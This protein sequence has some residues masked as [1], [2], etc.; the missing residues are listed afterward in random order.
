MRSPRGSAFGSFNTLDAIG[1]MAEAAYLQH[2]SSTPQLVSGDLAASS[3]TCLQRPSIALR[4]SATPGTSPTARGFHTPKFVIIRA[5]KWLLQHPAHPVV[6][7]PPSAIPASSCTFHSLHLTACHFGPC[8]FL[9]HPTEAVFGSDF[10]RVLQHPSSPSTPMERSLRDAL[11]VL[12]VSTPHVGVPM[13]DDTG[14]S[15]HTLAAHSEL[16]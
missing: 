6:A 5:A 2:P 3:Q 15:F 10:T 11:T 8:V 14:R 13:A 4:C 12:A 7:W 16:P 9:P 1:R